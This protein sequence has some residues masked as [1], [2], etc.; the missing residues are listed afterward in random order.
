[1]MEKLDRF[2]VDNWRKA[3]RFWS[4]QWQLVTSV[5]LGAVLLVPSMP[6]EI[7]AIVPEE[8]RVVAIGV[9]ALLGLWARLKQQK[10]TRP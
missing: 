10:G 9:W 3:W 4:V 1:M 2:L 6:G 7:A 5:I 8:W